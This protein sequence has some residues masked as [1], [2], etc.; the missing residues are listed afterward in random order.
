MLEGWNVERGLDCSVNVICIIL[1]VHPRERR[2]TDC[3]SFMHPLASPLRR[4]APGGP[5]RLLEKEHLL[6]TSFLLCLN[7][8]QAYV[9]SQ[10]FFCLIS[11]NF[12]SKHAHLFLL[13][14]DVMPPLP[15]PLEDLRPRLRW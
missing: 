1:A 6:K 2:C 11:L 3:E 13:L 8:F 5:V 15:K 7:L 14:Q 4:F 10:D 9:S 12:V